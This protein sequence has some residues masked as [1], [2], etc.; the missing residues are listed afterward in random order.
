MGS[1]QLLG[2]NISHNNQNTEMMLCYS[3]L[4]TSHPLLGILGPYLCNPELTGETGP[5]QRKIKRSRGA[6]QTLNWEGAQI[7]HCNSHITRVQVCTYIHTYI[8]NLY[9]CTVVSH[10]RDKAYYSPT[11]Y[12][13]ATFFLLSR[14]N[15]T[16]LP[17]FML[18]ENHPSTIAHRGCFP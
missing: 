4:C 12:A 15:N 18:C 10:F 11:L 3:H 7:M 1:R 9:I 6:E 17:P 14:Q 16:I 13:P 2:S 5:T 8:C